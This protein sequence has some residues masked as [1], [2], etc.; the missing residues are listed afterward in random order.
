MSAWR[1]SCNRVMYTSSKTP[2]SY[3]KN[4]TWTWKSID[5]FSS[6][7]RFV[8]TCESMRLSS[9]TMSPCSAAISSTIVIRS[10]DR[11]R[12]S[13]LLNAEWLTRSW[14]QSARLHISSRLRRNG[15]SLGSRRRFLTST[16]FG[17]IVKCSVSW[18][19]AGHRA[20]RCDC[21][22][23]RLSLLPRLK[24]RSRYCII[25]ISRFQRRLA[26]NEGTRCWLGFRDDQKRNCQ[27]PIYN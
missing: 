23:A 20:V 2:S 13:L 16:R 27:L 4:R 15:S 8:S 19:S 17:P 18:S 12:A 22:A 3:I 7:G 5:S 24:G 6:A 9:W 25:S 21:W 1:I 11:T 14:T 26:G 10:C